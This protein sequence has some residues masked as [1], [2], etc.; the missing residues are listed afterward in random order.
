MTDAAHA[1]S[2]G[3]ILETLI[4]LGQLADQMVANSNAAKATKSDDRARLSVLIETLLP[5]YRTNELHVAA[6]LL[7][8][9]AIRELTYVSSFGAYHQMM[10]TIIEGLGVLHRA[11]LVELRRRREGERN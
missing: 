1:P 9:I 2:P 10:L 4:T 5:V 8:A 11:E 7:L 6:S 3:S